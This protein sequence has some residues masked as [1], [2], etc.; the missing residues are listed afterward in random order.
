[1]ESGSGNRAAFLLAGHNVTGGSIRYSAHLAAFES[2]EEA[3]Q[4]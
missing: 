3:G 1:V 2:K 4:N